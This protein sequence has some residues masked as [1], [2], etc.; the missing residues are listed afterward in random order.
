MDHSKIPTDEDFDGMLDEVDSI[1]DFLR[2]HHKE[3]R[4]RAKHTGKDG[5]PTR[6]MPESSVSSGRHSDPTADLVASLAGGKLDDENDGQA[7]PDEWRIPAD[8]ITV[9]V[10]N[11]G[12]ELMDGRNRL[13]GAAGSLRT[14]LPGKIPDPVMEQCVTCW[15]NKRVAKRWIM[16]TSQCGACYERAR[17]RQPARFVG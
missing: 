10:N 4:R 15:V 12:R 11:M 16:E 9:S 8:P 7:T 13:R 3:A 2:Q 14:A 1:V 6:S 17:R 5:Y